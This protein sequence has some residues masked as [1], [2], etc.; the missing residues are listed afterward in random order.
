MLDVLYDII[1]LVRLL[2][3]LRHRWSTLAYDIVCLTYDVVR[4]IIRSVPAAET[5]RRPPPQADA[6]Q[7]GC[8]VSRD[9]I[10]ALFPVSQSAGRHETR[11]C[12]LDDAQNGPGHMAQRCPVCDLNCA[13]PP[14]RRPRASW[15]RFPCPRLGGTVTIRTGARSACQ[16][17]REILH[18]QHWQRKPLAIGGFYDRTPW[19]PE[20]VL[21]LVNLTSGTLRYYDIMILL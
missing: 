15:Y 9:V 13:D 16:W 3:N 20:C 14:S 4:L 10:F 7:H 12:A 21:A 6:C 5:T 17:K 2:L 11:A 19:Q 8:S 1:Y 18:V